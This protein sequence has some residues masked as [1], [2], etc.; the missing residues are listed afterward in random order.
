MN[1]MNSMGN[2]GNMGNMDNA[3][4]AFSPGDFMH[5]VFW[6]EDQVVITFHSSY[7]LTSMPPG[8]FKKDGAPIGTF[9][10]TPTIISSLN[11]RDINA[12]LEGNGFS[13]SSFGDKDVL[14]PS[15]TL[16]GSEDLNSQKGK[17]LFRA[18][19][20]KG[21]TV[22]GFFNF[23]AL[24]GGQPGMAGSASGTMPSGMISTQEDGQTSEDSDDDGEQ[25]P[26]NRIGNVPRLVNLINQN[27]DKFGT[28]TSQ[29]IGATPNWYS[30]ATTQESPKPVGCPLTPPIPVP[31][32][33]Y[34]P[35]A[36]GLWPIKVPE[37]SHD[38][39]LSHNMHSMTGDGVTVIILDTLP[40]AGDISRAV[41][42]AERKNL[43]LLDVANNVTLNHN[44][45]SFDLDTPSLA[46]P[47][48]GKDIYGRIVGFHMPDH[49]LFAAGI[50]RDLAPDANVECVRVLNDYCVGNMAML[51]KTL[52]DIHI[53]M[54]PVK[55]DGQEGD[56]HNK[57]V[58]INLSMA[59]SP[60]DGDILNE[61]LDPTFIQ[62]VR[63]SLLGP[64]QS[65]VDLGAVFAASAG[66]ESDP[67]NIAM[68]PQKLRFGPLYPAAFAYPPDNVEEMIP[69][70]AVNKYGDAAS[71]SNY[72]GSRGIATYGGELPE[73]VKPVPPNCMTEATDLDAMIGLYTALYYPAL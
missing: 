2:A 7:T 18:P 9:P 66:N 23:K 57:P 43:L 72:P 12:F 27:L 24:N 13:L 51:T 29:I 25:P 5:T 73:A 55:P 14:N 64:I 20:D 39:G 68:N 47:I 17:Y 48:A 70:G 16:S 31:A 32:D 58:V 53:R 54:L 63:S 62:N 71:Y 6:Q 61:G 37:L 46:Q 33:K 8:G 28:E 65:L 49:G 50:I 11:L 69:V 15:S 26:K 34:S 22:I 59:I 10:I 40:K 45:L 30:G 42:G 52:E 41:E 4:N 56:L 35:H 36:A 21:T 38:P 1:S 67:R 3:S 60:P 44:T 19:G